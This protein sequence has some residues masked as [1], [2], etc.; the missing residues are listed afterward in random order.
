MEGGTDGCPGP[1]P[2]AVDDGDGSSTMQSRGVSAS[3][4]GR[5][6]AR[7][8]RWVVTSAGVVVS[9]VDGL[10]PQELP[11]AILGG[12]L[13]CPR[14]PRSVEARPAGG[15]PD[16]QMVVCAGRG[17]V[18][19]ERR[20]SSCAIQRLTWRGDD[21][22]AETQCPSDSGLSKPVPDQRSTSP[23]ES[24]VPETAASSLNSRATRARHASYIIHRAR[25]AVG[26]TSPGPA[27]NE[28]CEASKSPARLLTQ[29]TFDR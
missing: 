25:P 5:A 8:T 13:V 4:G 10:C 19:R 11:R 26:R 24:P 29:I 14:T 6:M 22:E 3:S 28:R 27:L 7:W 17:E 15:G 23:T 1:G 12:D 9:L 16:A 20:R 21:L 2:V 18:W